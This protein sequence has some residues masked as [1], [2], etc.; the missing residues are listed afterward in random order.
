MSM[1][2]WFFSPAIFNRKE[3][4]IWLAL[5]GEISNSPELRDEHR[6]QYR[7]YLA[8]IAAAIAELAAHRAREVDATSLA[9]ALICLVDGLGL[10]HCI[11]ADAMPASDAKSACLRFL[12]PHL[13]PLSSAIPA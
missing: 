10:Q 7:H 2:A 6:R 9:K 12:E 4:N 5:W 11:D 1:I 13:G 3:L 8:E